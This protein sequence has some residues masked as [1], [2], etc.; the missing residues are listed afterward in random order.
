MVVVLLSAAAVVVV[1]SVLFL[2]FGA[3][4]SS[5]KKTS[6]GDDVSLVKAP[7]AV[8]RK[9]YVVPDRLISMRS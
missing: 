4:R 8:P 1:A 9:A 5:E 6:R 2:V 7:K 3:A